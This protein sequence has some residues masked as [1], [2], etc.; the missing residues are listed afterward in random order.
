V[1]LS[2]VLHKTNLPTRFF[3]LDQGA[4]G[5]ALAWADPRLPSLPARLEGDLRGAIRDACRSLPPPGLLGGWLAYEAGAAFERMPRRDPAEVG[6]GRL[7]S[8]AG[9]LWLGVGEP[10]I[11]GDAAFAKEAERWLA[12]STGP[13]RAHRPPT[14]PPLVSPGQREAYEDGVAQIID[15]IGQG[16]LYQ[17]NLAW[18]SPP[19]AVDDA[20]ALFLALRTANPAERGGLLR[21][22][23]TTLVSNSP[24]LLLAVDRRPDGALVARSCPIKGTVRRSAGPAAAAALWQSEKERAELTMIVD[25]VRNDLGRV[26]VPGSVKALPR[27]LRPCGDLLHAEQEVEAVLEPGADAVDAFAALFPAGSVTGAPKVRAMERIAA[28]EPHPRGAYC[29]AMGWFAADGSA[30]W[31]VAIRTLTLREGL[32][33]FHVGAG[34]VADSVPQS[35]WQ[36]TLAKAAALWTQL[37]GSPP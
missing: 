37:R 31:N 5:T 7:W 30:R 25:L 36:E 32:A 26:A 3:A 12:A 1:T 13:P 6:L 21:D 34:I 35:E 2:A 9:R 14:G 20:V 16:D 4:E 29:G 22:E 23:E 18:R 27:R 15:L 28:L 24:E 10:R 11:D 17:A 19:T 33:H 8:S